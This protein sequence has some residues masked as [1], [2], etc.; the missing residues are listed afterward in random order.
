MIIFAASG[1]AATCKSTEPITAGSV[2]IPI[3]FRFDPVWD[4]LTKTAVFSGSGA[5]VDLL[6]VI[7]GNY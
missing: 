3:V 7:A 2:G 6:V 4:G 5:T 1:R